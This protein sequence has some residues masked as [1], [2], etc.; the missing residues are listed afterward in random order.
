MENFIE[1]SEINEERRSEMVIR[2]TRISMWNLLLIGINQKESRREQRK[3]E[4]R[5][6]KADDL[7][8]QA[9]VANYVAKVLFMMNSILANFL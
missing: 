2:A 8:S 4:K 3:R 9:E 7:A 6:A 5:R 1:Q